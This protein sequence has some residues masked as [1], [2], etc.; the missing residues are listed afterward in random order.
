MSD[1]KNTN[2]Y[3]TNSSPRT[4]TCSS[5]KTSNSNIV[6]T[7]TIIPNT[8]KS[9]KSSKSSSSCKSTIL[10]NPTDTTSCNNC[11]DNCVTTTNPSIFDNTKNSTTC[12]ST[13]LSNATTLSDTHSLI[14]CSKSKKCGCVLCYQ[15]RKSHKN[16]KLHTISSSTTNS[17]NTYV[18]KKS[19]TLSN[20]N[21]EKCTNQ[22]T[23]TKCKSKSSKCSSSSSYSSSDCYIECE[24]LANQNIS[25]CTAYS[26]RAHPSC[27]AVK[28]CNK[29]INVYGMPIYPPYTNV[30]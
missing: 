21:S 7:C 24:N 13:S 10:S 23:N 6:S 3:S 12:N 18:Y 29:Y 2:K 26:Y 16:K 14:S 22:S 27:F 20:C 5:Y 1:S 28:Q 17:T 19:N 4:L 25:Q 11:S 9:S 15:K 8:C 30:K